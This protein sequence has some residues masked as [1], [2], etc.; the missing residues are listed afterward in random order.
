[1]VPFKVQQ[2]T[3]REGK[4]GEVVVIINVESWLKGPASVKLMQIAAV[5]SLSSRS[6]TDDAKQWTF[7]LPPQRQLLY[8]RDGARRGEMNYRAVIYHDGA[9]RK[10]TNEQL[11][12]LALINCSQTIEELVEAVWTRS[13]AAGARVQSLRT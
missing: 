8:D 2:T 9:N 12:N 7:H 1:M 4:E 5:S 6:V 11:A 3:A 10:N 13:V